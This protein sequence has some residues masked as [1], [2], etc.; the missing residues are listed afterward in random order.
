MGISTER[1]VE[2]KGMLE[3]RRAEMLANLQVKMRAVRGNGVQTK[4]GTLGV[5]DTEESSVADVQ[6]DIEFALIQLKAETLSRINDALARL[7]RGDYGNCVQCGREI[8]EK[9]LQALPFAVRCKTCEEAREFAEQ[10][11]RQ[12]ASRTTLS[13]LLFDDPNPEQ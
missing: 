8:A 5:V 1:Y 10:T 7:E 3:G 12:K 2:L 11:A 4:N 6:E 9:R 13:G